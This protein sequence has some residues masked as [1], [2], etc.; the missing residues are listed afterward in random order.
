V[1]SR[2]SAGRRWIDNISA[3]LDLVSNAGSLPPDSVSSRRAGVA[4]IA[5]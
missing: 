3:I 4:A 5:K 2:T 1:I